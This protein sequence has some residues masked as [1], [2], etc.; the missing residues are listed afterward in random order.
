MSDAPTTHPTVLDHLDFVA[1]VLADRALSATDRCD[2]CGAQAY[3]QAILP[4]GGELLFCAHHGR[5]NASKLRQ[6]GARIRDESGR[7]SAEES[8]LEPAGFTD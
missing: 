4:D 7:L 5:D 8:E 3:L 1:D 2:R 6:I